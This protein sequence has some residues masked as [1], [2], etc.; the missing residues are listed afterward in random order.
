M[1]ML[2]SVT[3]RQVF[4]HIHI[5]TDVHLETARLNDS[6]DQ[7]RAFLSTWFS[8]W[9]QAPMTCS[10]WLLSPDLKEFLPEDSRILRWQKAFDVQRDE[11]GKESV[12]TCVFKL[13]GAQLKEGP[14]LH[15]LREDTILQKKLKAFLLSGGTIS[16]GSGPLVRR[17]E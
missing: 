8:D 16:N 11:D 7:A 2:E 15:S 9:A 14:D 6:V 1:R 13:C 4:I 12:L 17:F 3:L 10:T 5:P